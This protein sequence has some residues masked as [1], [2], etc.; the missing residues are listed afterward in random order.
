MLEPL[1]AVKNLCRNLQ[2]SPS[3]QKNPSHAHPYPLKVSF[4]QIQP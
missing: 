1:K 2:K 4:T 3:P